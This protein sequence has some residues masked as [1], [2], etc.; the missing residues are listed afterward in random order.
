MVTRLEFQGKRQ[1]GGSDEI[2]A[3]SRCKMGPAPLSDRQRE[4][5]EHGQKANRNS[6][7]LGLH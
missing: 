4:Q 7:A 5:R 3:H 1:D 6:G 2:S